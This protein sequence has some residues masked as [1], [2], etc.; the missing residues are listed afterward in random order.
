MLME[1]LESS[2]VT[3]NHIREWT[4]R[5]PKLSRVLKQV[6][7][8]WSKREVDPQCPYARRK[9]ELTVEQGCLLW[10][11]RV[12]VPPQLRQQVIDEIHEG[13]P[14]INRMKSFARG[15]VWWPGMDDD[16]DKSATVL[17]VSAKPKNAEKGTNKDMAVAREAMD[18]NSHRP[19]WTS[20]GQDIAS[21]CGCTQQVD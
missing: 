18:K 15:Y 13:H 2:L 6:R 1:R 8:G 10:G 5:D 16:M 11:T 4:S 7:E 14:G 9:D 20:G 19:R 17:A 21:D 3:A 12:I